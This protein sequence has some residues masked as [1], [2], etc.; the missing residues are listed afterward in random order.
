MEFVK[1]QLGQTLE[2]IKQA[3]LAH[4]PIIYLPTEQMD[5]TLYNK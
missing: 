3:I 2:Q 5:N 1:T 4:V